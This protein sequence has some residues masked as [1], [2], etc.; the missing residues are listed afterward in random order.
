MKR[1]STC[2]VS[3][4][5]NVRDGEWT[6]DDTLFVPMHGQG[7]ELI[8]YLEAYDPVDRQLPDEETVRLLEIFAARA[9]GAIELQRA[10]AEL[11]EQSR[12]DGLTG[13]F[14]HGYFQERL[15]Q[16]V[17]RAA[18]TKRPL[19]VLMIDVDD[20]KEF[21]DTYGHPQGDRLLKGSPPC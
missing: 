1:M 8:G 3:S 10:Y 7:G 14:N 12:T 18:R 5:A 15:R 11:E 20:F 17:R 16:E 2:R 13:L 19:T 9:A 21:N 6:R 4:R